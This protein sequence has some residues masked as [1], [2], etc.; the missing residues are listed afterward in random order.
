[1]REECSGK[2]QND[3]LSPLTPHII[4][5]MIGHTTK[6]ESS[7]NGTIYLWGESQ[8]EHLP[9]CG[10]EWCACLMSGAHW[11]TMEIP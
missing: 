8:G 2:A 10:T 9:F 3:Y 1:M 11:V 6:D 7:K 4:W 5:D